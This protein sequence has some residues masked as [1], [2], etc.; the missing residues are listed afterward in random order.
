MKE[1]RKGK[2]SISAG[3]IFLI[4]FTALLVFIAWPR[5]GVPPQGLN[6]TTAKSRLLVIGSYAESF[7]HTNGFYPESMEALLTAKPPYADQ[8]Y[9]RQGTK[10]YQFECSFSK[11]G[12]VLKAIPL[13]EMKTSADKIFT[14]TNG[15]L[16]SPRE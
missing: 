16:L 4:L 15:C 12:Y 10:G 2:I 13:E 3:I 6:A 11:D 9:C 8:D 14:L 1:Q 7:R 5:L